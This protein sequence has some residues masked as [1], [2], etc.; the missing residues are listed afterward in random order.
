MRNPFLTLR[1][2]FPVRV[3]SE[4]RTGWRYGV[5]DRFGRLQQHVLQGTVSAADQ[6]ERSI[7]SDPGQVVEFESV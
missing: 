5:D 2:Y 7:R 3:Y 1:F 4:T 6:S